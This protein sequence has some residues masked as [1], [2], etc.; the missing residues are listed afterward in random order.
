MRYNRKDIPQYEK[1]KQRRGGIQTSAFSA[2]LSGSLQELRSLFSILHSVPGVE[3][4]II[5]TVMVYVSLI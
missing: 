2:K 4:L 5:S 1:S 3:T